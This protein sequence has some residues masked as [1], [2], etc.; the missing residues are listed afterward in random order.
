MNVIIESERVTTRLKSCW[1]NN[2]Q[3]KLRLAGTTS[4]A[5]QVVESREV[6]LSVRP[7]PLPSRSIVARHPNQAA[8]SVCYL[9]IFFS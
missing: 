7:N 9:F 1:G 3:R 6:G 2:P 5:A 8:A 4:R